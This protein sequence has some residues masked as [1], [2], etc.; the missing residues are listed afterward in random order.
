MTT[1]LDQA[2]MQSL[3]CDY[4]ICVPQDNVACFAGIA[5]PYQ[6]LGIFLIWVI[7]G[8]K[9]YQQAYLQQN[10][11]E[12]LSQLNPQWQNIQGS[13]LVWK[14]YKTMGQKV[15]AMNDQQVLNLCNMLWPDDQPTFA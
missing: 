14:I 2:R 5:L 12:L 6:D 8:A 15:Q 1:K 10:R 9:V 13:D 4:V 7:S 11:H 3:L